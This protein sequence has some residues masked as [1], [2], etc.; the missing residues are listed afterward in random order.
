MQ[1]DVDASAPT[2]PK[3]AALLSPSTKQDLSKLAG[4]VTGIFTRKPSVNLRQPVDLPELG[5]ARQGNLS[6]EV[7]KK[8]VMEALRRLCPVR[9]AG[10]ECG[11]LPMLIRMVCGVFYGLQFSSVSLRPHCTL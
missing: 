8:A 11:C 2:S 7:W 6:V 9:G 5:D 10:H 3:G 4:G 1:K